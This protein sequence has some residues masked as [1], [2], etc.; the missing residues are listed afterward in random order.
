MG[1]EGRTV[2]IVSDFV[3]GQDLSK[4]L[5]QKRP[6]IH[7]SVELC[8]RIAG[9]LHHA[10]ENGV[11][12]CD[13]KPA[14]IMLD[15]DGE[16]HIMDFGLAKRE[17]GEVTMTLDGQIMGTPAYMSPEQARGDARDADCRSDVYSLGVIL[18]ELLT[19]TLPFDGNTR[20]LL[21]QVTSVDAPS[22][23]KW[24]PLI[25][26]DLE[27]ICLK[28]LE[29]LSAQRYAS[30]QELRDDLHLHLASEP[31]HARR[32][33]WSVRLMRR[34]CAR[35]P[36]AVTLALMLTMVVSLVVNYQINQRFQ[37]GHLSLYATGGPATVEILDEHNRL[38]FQVPAPTT[39]AV[40]IAAG[41]YRLRVTAPGFRTSTWQALIHRGVESTFRI[42]LKDDLLWGPVDLVEPRA[43]VEVLRLFDAP[44]IIQYWNVAVTLSDGI[45]GRVTWTS[46][47]TEG[48]RGR[49]A[50]IQAVPDVISV[51]GV[52]TGSYSG[53]GEFWVEA[54]AGVDGREL[55]KSHSHCG[56]H[57]GT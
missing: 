57:G 34:T 55:W 4:W 38:V 56:P 44:S 10:H 43:K 49:D 12:H 50:N 41:D 7:E 46:K 19:G 26:R 35:H 1:R 13:L 8:A 48:D 37:V 33:H 11:V 14:N 23:K 16:P 5:Q 15:E 22:P 51:C 47:P 6:T 42:P 36:V 32:S 25:S 17:A 54:I 24:N 27:T 30:A 53:V 39:Q 20:H 3:R 40:P 28:C 31:V 52:R 21:Q 9:A 18:F 2:F 45:S 29:K